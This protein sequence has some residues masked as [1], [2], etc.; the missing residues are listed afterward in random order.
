MLDRTSLSRHPSVYLRM[1]VICVLKEIVSGCTYVETCTQAAEN[2]MV[3]FS[4]LACLLYIMC[5]F[6]WRECV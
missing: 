2:N 5:S 1:I 6:V 4:A 3:T